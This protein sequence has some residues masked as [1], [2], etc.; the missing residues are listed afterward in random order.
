ML[1][2]P[3]I[4]PPLVFAKSEQKARISPPPLI[5]VNTVLK[6]SYIYYVL[7]SYFRV[8]KT[9]CRLA[10]VLLCSLTVNSCALWFNSTRK[11]L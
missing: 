9:L 11:C 2:T 7:F 1:Q 3:S 10:I 4:F 8:D 6:V 5:S